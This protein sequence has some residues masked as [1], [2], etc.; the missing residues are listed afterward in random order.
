MKLTEKRIRDAKPGPKTYIVR[1]DDV[2]GLGLRIT[3]AGAKAYV[4]DY[5]A[6]GRRRLMTLARAG[7]IS[8][9]EARRR[10]GRERALIR[11]GAPDPLQRRQDA[12][13]APTVADGL[14]RF[15][16]EFAPARIDIGRMSPKTVHEYRLAG[17]KH[18]R[19]ALGRIKVA[20]VTRQD[21]ERMVDGLRPAT[22]NR[23]LAFT[24]RLFRLFETWEWRPQN[25]NPACGIER[26]RE[27]ARDRVLEPSELAALAAALDAREERFPGSVA[28]I[29]CAAVTGLRIGEILAIRWNDIAFET[30]RLT[31]PKTKTGRRVHDLP[32]AALAILASLHRLNAWPFTSGSDAPL[33]YRTVRTHFA[34]AVADAGLAD[35]R[36]HDLRRTV[37]TSAAAAGVGTHVLRDLLGHKSAAMADRY[38]R[39]VGN[40]VRDA[41]EQVGSQMAAMMKGGE[42]AK[43]VRFKR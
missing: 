31:M 20:A 18:L 39:D 13:A 11:D 9:A 24:S 33:T 14:D 1:D 10:A 26:A 4:L 42:G 30:G 16:A 22:R 32:T 36:L 41:R 43:V 17:G 28:A 35:V 21:I 12:I 6:A 3:P 5:H 7:E 15:F 27:D 29:R 19:P 23:V 34:A 8:L 38:V 37:M 2:I 25:A 40:P